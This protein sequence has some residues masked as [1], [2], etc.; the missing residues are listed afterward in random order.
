M[1]EAALVVISLSVGAGVGIL[2]V[3]SRSLRRIADA[4]EAA[5]KPKDKP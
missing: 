2:A 3:V 1:G 4:L 5:T